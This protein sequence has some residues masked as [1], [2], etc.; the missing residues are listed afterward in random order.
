M[1]R[2]CYERGEEKLQADLM[3]LDALQADIEGRELI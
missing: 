3:A 2:G 1:L